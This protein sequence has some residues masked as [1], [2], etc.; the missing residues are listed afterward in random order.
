MTAV[1]AFVFRSNLISLPV[2]C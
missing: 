2:F 1:V